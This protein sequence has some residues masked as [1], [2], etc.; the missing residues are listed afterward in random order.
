MLNTIRRIIL[1]IWIFNRI[2]IV[3]LMQMVITSLLLSG[4]VSLGMD[5]ETS[6]S[7]A[8]S[9][10]EV[11]SLLQR[12]E[13]EFGTIRS[14]VTDF[15]Q[16]KH[17]A[18]FREPVRS[19]GISIFQAPET[20][21]FEF[22]EPFK[23]V[24]IVK[25]GSVTKYEL[26]DGQWKR[27][28]PGDQQLV[29]MVI[30]QIS[31]WLEGRFR[32]Y[33]DIYT[34]SAVRHDATRLILTPKDVTIKR[35]IARIEIG[36]RNGRIGIEDITIREAG[37]DYTQIFFANEKQNILIPQGVFDVKGME[38]TSVKQLVTTAGS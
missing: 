23:S 6:E 33:E 12:L 20:I 15:E 2:R 16:V 24:L 19:R 31:S 34:I 1:K 9:K 5:R 10:A 37:E 26:V 13:K 28:E 32:E 17:L 7:A 36:L 18:I 11:D 35:H 21:R 25:D 29:L 8:L 22:I 4:N 27:L 14:L 38:P 3:M 30:R